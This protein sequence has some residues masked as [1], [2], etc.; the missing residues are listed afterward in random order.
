MGYLTSIL[1]PI[2]R[3]N[4]RGRAVRPVA[5]GTRVDPTVRRAFAVF[6]MPIQ[7]SGSGCLRKP[8]CTHYFSPLQF[9]SLMLQR[10]SCLFKNRY[11]AI[12]GI[13]TSS[14][15]RKSIS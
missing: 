8:A 7:Y 5:F 9:S 11:V 12:D 13:V 6:F 2:R 4:P 15:R 14:N 10:A 1:H 3:T